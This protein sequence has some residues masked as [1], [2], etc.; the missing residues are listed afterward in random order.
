MG[1]L[2]SL[3]GGMTGQ[4]TFQDFAQR[5]DRGSPW[6][7]ISDEETVEHYQRIAPQLAPDDYHDAAR[8]SLERL[9]PD[10]RQQ[11]VEH[12]QQLAR[13]SD[14]N[15]PGVHDDRL[16][17]DPDALAG[18]F[19]QLHAQQPG[20]LRQLLGGAMG[21]GAFGNPI[22]KAAMAGIA[23]MAVRKVMG[24]RGRGGF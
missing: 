5:Y 12:M 4:R 19:S 23:A 14:V 24:G 15:F 8:A 7:G 18:V 20:M 21:G 3:L 13:R 9:S 6:D 17:G 16:A 10:E 11:L 22:A 2:D 1:M